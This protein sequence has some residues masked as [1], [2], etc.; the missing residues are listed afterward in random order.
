MAALAVKSR[1]PDKRFKNIQ[2]CDEKQIVDK[3]F[4]VMHVCRVVNYLMC[5]KN[6][7]RI[8]KVYNF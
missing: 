3:K 6:Y 1:L 2:S 8:I 7:F 5:F 4:I